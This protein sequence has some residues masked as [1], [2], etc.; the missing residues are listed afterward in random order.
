MLRTAHGAGAAPSS[1]GGGGQRSLLPVVVDHRGADHREEVR[2]SEEA[3]QV[4]RA[5]EA[6]L[7]LLA[8]AAAAECATT[9]F[10]PALAFPRWRLN[11]SATA[12]NLLGP[13]LDGLT[14]GHAE[15]PKQGE[16]SAACLQFRSAFLG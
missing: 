15:L 8:L 13:F 10:L 16:P 7:W 11:A 6:Y 14:Y 1:P 2:V 5:N 9:C 3:L 12:L 4:E